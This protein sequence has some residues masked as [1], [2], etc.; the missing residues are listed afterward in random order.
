MKEYNLR[1]IDS[2]N[3]EAKRIIK[4]GME[5]NFFI[6]ADEQ[7][8]GRGQFERTFF[9]P[10]STGLYLSVALKL[11][12]SLSSSFITQATAVAVCDSIDTLHNIKLGIKPV[13]DLFLH[14]RKVGGILVETMVNFAQE[15]YFAI[16]GIGLNLYAPAGGFPQEIENS[17]SHIFDKVIDKTELIHKIT[18]TLLRFSGNF[19]EPAIAAKYRERVIGK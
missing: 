17:A 12:E 13:N 2:T 14:G 5:E 11:T 3:D 6:V 8:A 10:H 18:D 15:S 19:E 7:T 4:S 9:S 16:F 1:T